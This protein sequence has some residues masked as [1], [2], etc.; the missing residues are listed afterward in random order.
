M[1]NPEETACASKTTWTVSS[2]WS[3]VLHQSW[4]TAHCA[5][6]PVSC[7]FR[8]HKAGPRG[9]TRGKKK[10]YMLLL[11][12]MG[13]DPVSLFSVTPV[14]ALTLQV[15]YCWGVE[16]TALG[17]TKH[18]QVSATDPCEWWQKAKE[19]VRLEKCGASNI[20]PKGQ[21]PAPFRQW[22]F[23]KT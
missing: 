21:N 3:S 16:G 6:W 10:V 1:K 5:R 2:G 11:A 9:Q 23:Y 12:Y 8:L 19:T 14:T 20:L 7:F 13:S 4:T 15:S 22:Q 17:W 18:R